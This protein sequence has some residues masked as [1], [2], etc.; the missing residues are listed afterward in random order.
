MTFDILHKD[1]NCDCVGFAEED[2]DTRFARKI[3]K[4]FLREYDFRIKEDGS[5]NIL[6][7]KQLCGLR[8]ISINIWNADSQEAIIQKYKTSTNFSPKNRDSICVFKF[9]KNAGLTRHTPSNQDKFHYDFY[10]SDQFQMDNIE[11]QEIL[12]LKDT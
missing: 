11:I 8:G 2:L 9:N 12:I 4:P 7:C 6:N 5:G 10:K 3:Y 1:T